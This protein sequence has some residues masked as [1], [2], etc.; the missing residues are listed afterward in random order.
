MLVLDR[1][2]GSIIHSRTSDLAGFLPPE[3]LLVFNNSKVRKARIYGTSLLTEGRVEFLLIEEICPGSWKAMT[4]KSRKQTLGKVFSFPGGITGK[5]TGLDGNL[6]IITFSEKIDDTYLDIHGHIPL[7]PYIKRTD[8]AEDA[9]RYQTIYAEKN[10]SVAA[11]TAGLHF[12]AELLAKLENKGL[13]LEKITLHVGL[14]TFLPLRTREIEEHIM[15]EETYEISESAA[16]RITQARRGGKPVLAVGTTSVRTLESSW[17]ENRLIPGKQKTNL[18]ILPGY[19]FK[20]VD[21]L[22]T[23]FHTPESTLLVLVSAFAGVDLIREAYRE[24]VKE[25]YRFFSYGDAMLIL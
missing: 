4:E 17:D 22:F 20:V 3:T 10:G 23:N 9:Q 5:I 14:G 7:P 11:P 18:Y 15:H 21:Y 16:E 19:S 25:R 24:A 2:T 6:R 13:E 8:T 1:K 12:T